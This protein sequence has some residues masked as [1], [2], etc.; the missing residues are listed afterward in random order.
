MSILKKPVCLFYENRKISDSSKRLYIS[1]LKKLNGNVIPTSLEFLKNTDSIM[2]QLDEMCPNTRRSGLIAI[3][4]AC[5][6]TD[7]HEFYTKFMDKS[8]QD[9]KKMKGV[10]S[11]KQKDNWM[12]L[13][14]LQKLAKEKSVILKVNKKS[15]IT[16]SE[17][18]A[19]LAYTILCLYTMTPPR[20]SL[21]YVCMKMEKNEGNYIEKKSFIFNTFKTAKTYSTQTVPIPI[22]LQKVI[23]VYLKY[24]PKSDYFLVRKDGVPLNN[25]TLSSIL[26]GIT[27]KKISTQMLRSIYSTSMA[28]P[29]LDKL[30]KMSE[31]MGTSTEMLSGV[32]SK[33]II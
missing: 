2:K 22:P 27:G 11:E 28:K 19:L 8:N 24:K 9:L 31:N 20:R 21:D 26:Y 5:K 30:E 3:V 32:Y 10:L 29:L 16:E 12:S 33:N 15:E 7:L 4:S 1:K 13:E 23:K 18:D 14:E 6:G 25:K 17:Y